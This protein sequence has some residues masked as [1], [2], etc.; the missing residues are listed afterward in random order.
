MTKPPSR[1][2][3]LV[4]GGGGARGYAHIGVIEVLQ[5]RGYEII[6]VAGTSMGALI[7]GLHAAGT[8]DD[9]TD[10]VTSL[11]QR[12]VVRLLDVTVCGPGGIRAEKIFAKVNELIGQGWQ[13][14]G[15]LTAATRDGATIF[16][17]PMV[18]YR[19]DPA[20]PAP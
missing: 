16:V 1:T 2:V 11:T 7:G 20:R 15:A 17:Q 12:D 6:A 18:R 14:F 8:L 3:A 13:P 4:L 10:W 9:Y 5:E 19:D